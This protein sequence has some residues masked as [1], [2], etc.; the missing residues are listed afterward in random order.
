MSEPTSEELGISYPPVAI[1]LVNWNNW[2]DCV[3]CID[4]VL[5]LHYPNFHI[6]VVDNDSSDESVENIANWCHRP[7]THDSWKNLPGVERWSYFLRSDPLPCRT[8]RADGAPLPPAPAGC[9][10][11]VIR[12]GSN[13]GFAGGCNV[14]LRCAST[15]LFDFFWLLNTDTVVHCDALAQLI[16][17]ARADQRIGM[18]G[19][20]VLYY[21]MPD[22]VQAMAGAKLHPENGDSRHIGE[23]RA[24]HDVPADPEVVERELTY[25]FGAS[26]LVSSKLIQQ[27]GLMQ[28]DYFLYYEEMDWAMRSRDLFKFAYAP[29][30]LVYHKSGNSSSKTMPL[31][32]ANLYYRNRIRFMSRF[33]PQFL[34]A[35]KRTLMAAMIRAF[36][37]GEWPQARLLMGII[38][39]ADHIA[40]DALRHQSAMSLQ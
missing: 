27:V 23:G 26:M 12:S 18:V 25:I 2:R 32:T 20:T 30:S 37:K 38:F 39:N 14:G 21:D 17:R 31:F 8:I 10:V 15:D 35:T 36:I 5:R 6:F 33:F 16:T 19:S 24:L 3:E 28:E 1:I 9:H 11:S 13:L 29:Q 22:R 7:V 40:A 34:G 4:S